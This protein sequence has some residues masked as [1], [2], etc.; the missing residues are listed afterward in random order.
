MLTPSSSLSPAINSP[1]QTEKKLG[2]RRPL[3]WWL[4][5]RAAACWTGC[6]EAREHLCSRSGGAKLRGRRVTT[7]TLTLS[8]PSPVAAAIT[9]THLFI[10]LP[11][12]DPNFSSKFPA[13]L[14]C[15]R[16]G[17]YYIYEACTSLSKTRSCPTTIEPW[18]GRKTTENILLKKEK[19]KKS[20]Y[21]RQ[22]LSH[23]LANAGDPGCAAT[24]KRLLSLLAT[25]P[26][27][28][29]RESALPFAK[30]DP[31]NFG[32]IPYPKIFPAISPPTILV[33]DLWTTVAN[34]SR[35]SLSPAVV[36]AHCPPTLYQSIRVTSGPYKV[37]CP[38][39]FNVP[40]T[41]MRSTFLFYHRED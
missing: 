6:S 32:D 19:R 14:G 3:P 28:F 9:E 23:Y 11:V 4:P 40:D 2:M 20:L 12:W 7:A 31:E 22:L 39:I 1:S 34:K 16:P 26:D 24:S 41:L 21:D 17:Q 13:N 5:K 38:P 27:Q 25:N 37:S 15:P 18:N 30:K 36:G 35:R 8:E 29:S 33:S 10:V